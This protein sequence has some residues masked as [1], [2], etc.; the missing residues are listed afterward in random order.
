MNDAK[1]SESYADDVITRF[2]NRRYK[3]NGEG[4]LFT[5]EHCKSDLR[6][7]EI[8]YQMC[9]YLDGILENGRK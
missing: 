6:S 3:R 9:W 4:G 8:W 2:L 1:F 7:A 5:V